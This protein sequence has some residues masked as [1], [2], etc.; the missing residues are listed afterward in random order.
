[1]EGLDENDIEKSSK[2]DIKPKFKVEAGE[3]KTCTILSKISKK[4]WADDTEHL[5]LDVSYQG[6]RC[7]FTADSISFRRSYAV[8]LKKKGLTEDDMINRDI[9][10]SA[11]IGDT[12]TRKNVKLYNVQIVEN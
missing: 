5:T 6:L 4:T 7:D 10:V 1:M 3:I 2:I 12:A 11:N 8:E 9:V